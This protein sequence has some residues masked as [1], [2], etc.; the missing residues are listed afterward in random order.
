MKTRLLLSAGALALLGGT[1][2]VAAPMGDFDGP[3]ID[4]VFV[5]DTTGSMSGL[6]DGA[7]RRIWGIANEV[8]ETREQAQVRFGLIG[9]RDRGDEYVTRQYD[10]TTDLYGIYGHLLDF[11]AAGGG[12]RPE[13]VNQALNEAV[14]QMNWNANQDTLR[15]VFLVGDSPPHLDYQDDVQYSR[16]LELADQRDITVNTVLAGT[17]SDTANIWREIARLG[18]GSFLTIPQD[19]GVTVIA[20]PYDDQISSLQRRIQ[21]TV[22]P[23]GTRAEQDY[24]AGQLA[25]AYAA[26]APVAADM[27]TN[28][29]RSGRV[30]EV[31]TGGND[32]VQDIEDGAIALSEVDASE[33]P[34]RYADLNTEEIAVDVDRRIAERAALNAELASLI[35]E[36]DAWVAEETERLT[37]ETGVSGFD[38]EVARTIREQAAERGIA[39]E[40]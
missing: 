19:G 25:D 20:S 38:L 40:D 32:L 24:L 36:R 18:G 27:A 2:A 28:R 35:E 7:K 15:L 3:Q 26:S 30:N 31:L 12:D 11:Q 21:D 34:P 16:T 9:F 39:Y 10:L 23:Y 6:I 8:L 37:A 13:S 14:T 4:V 29:F 5:L 33:L 22:V 17:A 1:N